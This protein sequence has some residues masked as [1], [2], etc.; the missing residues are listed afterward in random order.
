MKDILEFLIHI[1]NLSPIPLRIAYAIWCAFIGLYMYAYYHDMFN[2][3]PK[4]RRKKRKNYSNAFIFLGI[5]TVVIYFLAKSNEWAIHQVMFYGEV[6][7]FSGL[8][9]MAIGLLLIA[10]ARAALNGYW[11]P[12]IY[13][14]DMPNDNILISRG[15]YG[16]LRHPIYLGQVLMAIGTLLL[17]NS[18]IF[19][20]FAA[21][22]I[23]INTV[24]SQREEVHLSEMFGE[25]FVHYSENTYWLIPG[26]L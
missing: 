9:F 5:L 8:P 22:L 21:P 17:S 4:P 20:L 24:R 23:A 13:I 14:Y 19:I 1:Y 12:H 18:T 25:N 7:P 2:S 6:T 26:V 11:G 15:I 3:P 10:A 16:K